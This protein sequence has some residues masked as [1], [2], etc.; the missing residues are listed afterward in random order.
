MTWKSELINVCF[1]SRA[2][3]LMVK[4]SQKSDLP[5]SAIFRLIVYWFWVVFFF[6]ILILSLLCIDAGC[7][8]VTHEA[9]NI[10]LNPEYL[11]VLSASP[12]SHKSIHLSR[13]PNLLDM[14][15]SL[16]LHFLPVLSLETSVCS[17][18]KFYPFFWDHV[19]HK[20]V[21]SIWERSIIIM[22]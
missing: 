15:L 8:R 16:L 20:I 1:D 18:L 9:D 5:W 4:P 17:I 19:E 6:Y 10:L 7:D 2:Q 22:Y 12:I 21:F 14:S 13:F 11:V 3:K